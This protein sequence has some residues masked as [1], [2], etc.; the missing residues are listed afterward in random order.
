LDSG[1]S[2]AEVGQILLLDDDTVRQYRE[3]YLGYGAESLLTDNNNGRKSN[4]SDSQKNELES[5]LEQNTYR[6][7]KGIYSSERI[8]V[9]SIPEI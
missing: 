4:L 1:F 3:M 5:H 2:C 7:S 8:S 6:D 9:V